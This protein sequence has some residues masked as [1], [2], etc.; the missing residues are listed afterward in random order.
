VAV[1]SELIEV[2][3]PVPKKWEGKKRLTCRNATDIVRGKPSD[4]KP[5]GLGRESC[6]SPT[7]SSVS[8]SAGSIS[9]L[10]TTVNSCQ[11]P[12]HHLVSPRVQ[13]GELSAGKCAASRYPNTT[14]TLQPLPPADPQPPHMSTQSFMESSRRSSQ[15]RRHTKPGGR[16]LQSEQSSPK[17]RVQRPLSSI[18]I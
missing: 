4:T 13:H 12:R 10:G 8:R 18:G 17:H 5:N 1:M 3:I 9:R 2:E 15:P 11:I 14:S 7:Q 6:C 16:K